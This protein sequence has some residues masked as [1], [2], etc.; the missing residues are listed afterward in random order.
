VTG[1]ID[2]VR[3][4]HEREDHDVLREDL[5][6]L[7]A[8]LVQLRDLAIVAELLIVLEEGQVDLDRLPK[9][10]HVVGH[11]AL[12]RVLDTIQGLVGNL[13]RTVLKA[14]AQVQ[15]RLEAEHEN[16]LVVVDLAKILI[17]DRLR[18][19]PLGRLLQLACVQ[20]VGNNAKHGPTFAVVVIV[21][22]FFFSIKHFLLKK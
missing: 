9:R 16:L 11:A 10:H 13:E 19:Q 7:F 18:V 5:K 3:D 1:P 15:R 2:E 20:K 6:V 21:L 12:Q 4:L 17:Q 22:F 8:E 14:L